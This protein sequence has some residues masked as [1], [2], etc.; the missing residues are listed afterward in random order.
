MNLLEIFKGFDLQLD[1]SEFIC[2]CQFRSLG[3]TNRFKNDYWLK[4]SVI[5]WEPRSSFDYNQY[6]SYLYIGRVPR[7]P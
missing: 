2:R 5:D 3:L 7:V 4:P 6:D 1:S